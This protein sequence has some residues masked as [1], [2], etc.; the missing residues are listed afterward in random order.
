VSLLTA[1]VT[2][3][4]LSVLGVPIAHS[5]L[6]LVVLLLMVSGNV[7]ATL[8][9]RFIGQERHGR[10]AWLNATNATL[11]A[12][13]GLAI[14]MAGADVVGY[15]VAGLVVS[16]IFTAF[17][18]WASGIHISRATLTSARLRQAAGAGLPFLG[19]RLAGSVR[20]HVGILLLAALLQEQ[21]VGWWAAAGRITSISVFI[22]NVIVTPLL[23]AL[24]RQA[25]DA[26]AFQRLVQRSLVTVL[27]LTVPVN[28][29]I[30]A[31][32]P[33]V[34]DLLGWGPSFLPVVP[35]IMVLAVL[36][37]LVAASMV[38]G[39]ALIALHHERQWL[40]IAVTAT[41]IKPGLY[42]GLIPA[43][44]AGLQHGAIGA[45]VAEVIVE[46]FVVCGALI[47]LPR[48]LLGP[49]TALSI[50]GIMLAAIAQ[51]SFVLLL[52]PVSPLLAVPAGSLAF[53]GVALMTRVVTLK[54]LTQASGMLLKRN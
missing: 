53:L 33:A 52:S 38:L 31:L 36:Q 39:T 9:A 16:V 20:V 43:F 18:W 42:L 22:P 49:S 27:L 37:P 44:A 4:A 11:I 8:L 17:V 54:E 7:Q 10:Y 19:W 34:P 47:L 32:A 5:G 6:L 2:A 29:M 26:P 12:C 23:P 1:V 48:R 40:R 35:L 50:L 46:S 25:H 24:S 41:V 3:T 14:L 28:A 15:A 45:A 13:A 21:A 30:L 51:V